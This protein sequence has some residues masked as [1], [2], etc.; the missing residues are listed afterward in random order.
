MYYNTQPQGTTHREAGSW[1][2]LLTNSPNLTHLQKHQQL[3]PPPPKKMPPILENKM[4][5]YRF[6][7]NQPLPQSLVLLLVVAGIR[8]VGLLLLLLLLLQTRI[9]PL[10]GLGGYS[11]TKQTKK[12]ISGSNYKYIIYFYSLKFP[13]NA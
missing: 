12:S 10:S 2:H 5:P 6:I 1:L 13:K 3:H 9:L 8:S 11:V 7:C 4:P